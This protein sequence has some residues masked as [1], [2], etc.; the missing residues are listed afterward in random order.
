[1]SRILKPLVFLVEVCVIRG[2]SY[3]GASSPS[4][5]Q[6]RRTLDQVITVMVSRFIKHTVDSLFN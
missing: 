2:G 1:M 3:T 6:A 5:C 4:E